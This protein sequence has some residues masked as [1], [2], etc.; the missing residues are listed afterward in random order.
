MCGVWIVLDD[1]KAESGPLFYYPK[2]HHLT[3]LSEKIMEFHPTFDNYSKII[4]Y[5]EN[6]IRIK[7]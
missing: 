2:S 1:I 6:Q 4:D 5:C 3:E 7:F